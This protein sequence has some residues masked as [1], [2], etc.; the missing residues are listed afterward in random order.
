MTVSYQTVIRDDWVE[1]ETNKSLLL[2]FNEQLDEKSNFFTLNENALEN[3]TDRLDSLVSTKDELYWLTLAR[4]TELVLLC[5]GNYANN[6][7]FTLMGD[8][9]LNPRLV[10]I[11]IRG[12]NRPIVKKRHTLLTD[13]FRHMAECKDEIIQW[14][15][16]ETIVEIKV[17][18][19][20]PHL[21]DRLEKSGAINQEYF[22]SVK[23]RNS[24]IADLVGFLNCILIRDS[25]SLFSWLKKATPS[26]RAMVEAKLIRFD[27]EPFF[28]LDRKIKQM[29]QPPF[30][31]QTFPNQMPFLKLRRI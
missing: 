2:N 30:V 3:L 22:E 6:G 26:D 17:K 15:K 1:S 29:A 25:E 21:L 12:H 8:L 31:D 20:L 24:Q 28:E 11:H 7:E 19:L 16:K 27:F 23:R 4:I 18:A 5:A 9:L 14:L 10:L 13:Q